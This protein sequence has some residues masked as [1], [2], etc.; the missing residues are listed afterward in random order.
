MAI[1]LAAYGYVEQYPSALICQSYRKVIFRQTVTR[2]RKFTTA[3]SLAG[4]WQG[5]ASNN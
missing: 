5:Y 1:L 4:S 2:S 3:R